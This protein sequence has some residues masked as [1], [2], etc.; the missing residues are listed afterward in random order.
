MIGKFELANK[1]T[2]F[3]DEINGMPLDLQAKLLRVL[4]QNEIMRLGDTQPVPVDVRVI[5]ATN[6]DLLKEVKNLN[7]REDLYYRLN[8]VEIYIPP[9]RERA[10]DLELLI[11]HVMTRQSKEMNIKK[12]HLSEEVLEISKVIIGREMS[13]KWK[14]ASNARSCSLRAMWS[15]GNICPKDF[16]KE[17][18][19]RTEAPVPARWVPGNGAGGL[20]A[21]PGQCRR[22]RREI[23]R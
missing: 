14:T 8:V 17:R 3:L 13:G 22:W 5:S 4:Q 10:A 2:L 12:P 23:S 11:D 19:R 6:A 7:F 9:L 18:T 16:G 15:A 1:G 20:K 21:K